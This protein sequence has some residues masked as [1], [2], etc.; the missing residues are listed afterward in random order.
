MSE[1]NDLKHDWIDAHPF[2]ELV[3]MSGVSRPFEAAVDKAAEALIA[4]YGPDCVRATV[5]KYTHSAHA[6]PQRQDSPV[7]EPWS[8]YVD[9]IVDDAA[10]SAPDDNSSTEDEYGSGSE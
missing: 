4:E 8:G 5:G 9:T 10:F 2:V 1:I 6:T 3:S 7:L